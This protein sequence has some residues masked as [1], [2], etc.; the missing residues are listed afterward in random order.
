MGWKNDTGESYSIIP[1]KGKY[2]AVPEGYD[3]SYETM[4]SPDMSNYERWGSIGDIGKALSNI[5]TGTAEGF[6]Y[7][8]SDPNSLLADLA[9]SM[10]LPPTLRNALKGT[11]KT[12]LVPKQSGDA[13]EDMVRNLQKEG[14]IGTKAPTQRPSDLPPLTPA[15]KKTQDL[16][17]KEFSKKQ[18]IKDIN[19]LDDALKHYSS[20]KPSRKTL[21]EL[22]E[23]LGPRQKGVPASYPVQQTAKSSGKGT[24][25]DIAP[26]IPFLI[27]GIGVQQMKGRGSAPDAES[28]HTLIDSLIIDTEPM[29]LRQPSLEEKLMDLQEEISKWRY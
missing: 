22:G 24:L 1:E 19:M 8:L 17:L 5:A 20:K 26:L 27:G 29:E 18:R 9:L 2:T 25:K 7:D 6:G 23:V 14:K 16:M 28:A 15:Q 13:V 21:E 3:T 12:K 10:F 4:D 11:K